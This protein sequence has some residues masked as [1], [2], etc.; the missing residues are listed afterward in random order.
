MYVRLAFAVATSV[1]PDILI[2][3]EALSVG[4]GAFARKSFD[5]IMQLKEAGIDFPAPLQPTIPTTSP[6]F[7]CKFI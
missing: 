6:A 5:R 4:D 7:T 3:D 2:I 1:A